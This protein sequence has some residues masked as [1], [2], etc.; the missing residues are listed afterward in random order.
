MTSARKARARTGHWIFFERGRHRWAA[1]LELKGPA[2]PSGRIGTKTLPATRMAAIVC[3]PEVVSSR[4]VYRTLH[5]R[6]RPQ[7]KGGQIPPVTAVRKVYAG[8]PWTDRNAGARCE[9]QFRLRP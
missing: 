7:R 8:D 4:I 1:C 3:D 5:D 9:V 2:S 6:T